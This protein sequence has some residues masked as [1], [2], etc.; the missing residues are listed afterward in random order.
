[1]N[2]VTPMLDVFFENQV[3]NMFIGIE[4]TM[5]KETLFLCALA[6]STYTEIMG[7]LVTGFLKIEGHS[8]E[9]YEAFLPYL[10]ERYVKLNEKL[11]FQKDEDGKPNNLYRIVRSKFVHEFQPRPSYGIW[12]SEKPSDG[13]GLDMINDNLNIHL[14]N[15]YRDFRAGVNKYYEKLK[16]WENNQELFG[17]FI[18]ATVNNAQ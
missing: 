13:I 5:K 3:K 4:A 6:L 9:S 11:S 8:R 18:K 10:G 16:N 2:D 14:T 7:G 12:I 1:M 17:N 15:Y